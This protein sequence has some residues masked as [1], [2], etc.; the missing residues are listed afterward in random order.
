MRYNLFFNTNGRNPT[1]DDFAEYF[2]G[3]N[4]YTLNDSQAWYENRDTGVYF[5]FELDDDDSD[6]DEEAIDSWSSFN[7]N[8]FR[9]HFFGLEALPELEAFVGAFDAMIHDPQVDGMGTGE[10]SADG[11]IRG[12]NH[13]NHF[14]YRAMLTSGD[15]DDPIVYPTQTL[16]SIWRW[17]F[18]RDEFQNDVGESV[19]VPRIMFMKSGRRPNS[20]VVWPDAIPIYLPQADI[21]ILLRNELS[22]QPD[23]EDYQ[24]LC[25]VGWDQ[26]AHLLHGFTNDHRSL[27]YTRLDFDASPDNIVDFVRTQ[28]IA[29][30]QPEGMASD[31]ILDEELVNEVT[32]S[33]D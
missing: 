2:G 24:E 1:A 7:I 32:Q 14:A 9:P 29:D 28:P 27:P 31:Q 30:P 4:H 10:F 15:A 26:L 19:Y 3:R 12:W 20:A 11:F 23:D 33:A 21:V 13:S 8:L 5:S 6:D 25:V 16:E 22:G 18:G 17:N